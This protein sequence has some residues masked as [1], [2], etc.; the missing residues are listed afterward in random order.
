MQSAGL[1][2]SRECMDALKLRENSTYPVTRP[3]FDDEP[4]TSTR[5][6]IPAHLRTCPYSFTLTL[7]TFSSAAYGLLL[8]ASRQARWSSSIPYTLIPQIISQPI[9]KALLQQMPIIIIG[10]TEAPKL[11]RDICCITRL[12]FS[13]QRPTDC[14]RLFKASSI[15]TAYKLITSPEYRYQHER[16]ISASELSPPFQVLL[17]V[18]DAI[19]PATRWTADERANTIAFTPMDVDYNPIRLQS[20]PCTIYLTHPE[21]PST[22]TMYLIRPPRHRSDLRGDAH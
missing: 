4:I 11:S 18:L 10:N 19:Q 13:G 7:P 6:V 1:P 2:T 5:E 3:E 9:R 15:Y 17:Q 8:L 12:A 16:A 14:H 22:T 21:N 20:M